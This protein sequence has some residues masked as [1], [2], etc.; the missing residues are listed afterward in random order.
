MI[1]ILFYSAHKF[2][3]MRVCN[4]AKQHWYFLRC[5]FT[6]VFYGFVKNTKKTFCHYNNISRGKRLEDINIELTTKY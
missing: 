1:A 2:T 6:D 5:G 3:E 4:K